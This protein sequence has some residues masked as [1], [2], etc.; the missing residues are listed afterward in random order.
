MSFKLHL[1]F[2]KSFHGTWN[3]ALSY[4]LKILRSRWFEVLDRCKSNGH[5]YRKVL[6]VDDFIVS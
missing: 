3:Q 1:S 4:I 2:V 6:S 5:L